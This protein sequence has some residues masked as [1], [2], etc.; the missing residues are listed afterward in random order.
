MKT[1]QLE[2]STTRKQFNYFCKKVEYWLKEFGLMEWTVYY[3]WQNLDCMAEIRYDTLARAATFVLAKRSDNQT[4]YDLTHSA[5]HEVL[6]LVLADC[7]VAGK[8]RWQ[9]SLSEFD[10]YEEAAVCRLTA[11][12]LNLSKPPRSRG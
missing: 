10:S 11:L 12:I 1:E 2:K 9:I 6:H 7:A 8:R 5:L 4:R 3:L